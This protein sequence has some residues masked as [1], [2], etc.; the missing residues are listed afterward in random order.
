MSDRLR[1]GRFHHRLPGP[2]FDPLAPPPMR[3][4]PRALVAVLALGLALACQTVADPFPP[5]SAVT[6][7]ITD[8]NVASQR[9][10]LPQPQIAVWEIDELSIK[11][12][13]NFTGTFDFLQASPCSYQLNALAP[14]SLSSACRMSG[15][16]LQPVPTST[17]IIRIAISS[18]ELR[19]A[20]RPDLNLQA[21]PDGDGIPNQTDNCPIV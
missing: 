17:G 5:Q 15:L 9:F 10:P 16:S 20:A 6:V 19:A 8:T 18:L 14:I 21:D 2:R 11:N 12:L 4:T 3:K 1:P 13:T 7:T